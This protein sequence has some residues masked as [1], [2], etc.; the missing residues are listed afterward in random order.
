MPT[1]DVFDEDR[2]FEPASTYTPF[3]L[4]GVTLGVSICEDIWNY[5][6]FFPHPRYRVDPMEKIAQL[7]PNILINISASPFSVDKQH[8][9]HD[10]ARR[11]ALRYG[12][13]IVYVNQVGGNDELIFDGRSTVI[14]SHGSLMATSQCFCRRFA[15]G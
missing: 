5:K 13:P 6:D 9:R 15:D 12:L 10:L 14:D 2:Y 3:V 7:K 1:Y 11:H 4:N 8:L